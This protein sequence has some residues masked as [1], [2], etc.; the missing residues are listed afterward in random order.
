MTLVSVRTYQWLTWLLP[1]LLVVLVR[2]V[3]KEQVLSMYGRITAVRTLAARIH[4][5]GVH[6][7][8]LPE[9][10][11][12][13]ERLAH[14]KME[15]ASSLLGAKSEA[16]LYDLLMLKARESNVAIVSMTPR[17]QRV[18]GDFAELPLSIEAAGGFND[19]GR[20]IGAIENVNR[21]MR[22]EKLSM[23]KDR[24]GRL[25]AAIELLVYRYSDTLGGREPGTNRQEA[26]FQKREQYLVDL[27]KALSVRIPLPKNTFTLTGR[28]DPFGTVAAGPAATRSAATAGPKEPLSLVLKGILWKEPPLAIL[29]ALD[30]RTYIVKQGD[31][32][33]GFKV[34]SITRNEVVIA[35]PQG[36]HVLHQYDQK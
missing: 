34:S 27:D 25:T 21:L 24:D 33:N 22:V 30:G 15:I 19:L 5:T 18:G 9:M 14:K 28:D 20:F 35:T 26:A 2:D 17:Q 6:V 16:G 3:F 1:V 31:P 12:D 29:E 10:K 4:K 32:V 7:R 13:L 23:E 36:N 8:E 11:N